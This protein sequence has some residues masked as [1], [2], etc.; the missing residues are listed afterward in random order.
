V[1]AHE[2]RT[3]N[4]KPYL[5]PVLKGPRFEAHAIPLEM[6]RDFAVLEEMVVEVAKWHFLREHPER[7]RAPRGFSDGVSLTLSGV[8]D[9]S[10]AAVITLL[11][12]PSLLFHSSQ[13]YLEQ[14]RDS[15]VGAISAAGANKPVFDYL[16]PKALAYFDRL[17]RSLRDGE[18]IEFPSADPSFP[19]RLTKE[20]RRKLL[21]ASPE[22]TQLTEEIEV[23]GA[24]HEFNQDAM[25]FQMTL[26]D[27]GAIPGSIASQ[28]FE[29]VMEAFA[30][31]KQG[32][33]ILIRGIGRFNRLERLQGIDSIEHATVL[34]AQDVTT[35]LQELRAIEDGW[36]DGS[37][38]APSEEGLNWLEGAVEQFYP[39]SLPLP[40]IYPV[41]TGAVQLEWPIASN[42]VSLEIDLTRRSGEW[43]VLD[44]ATETE[45]FEELDLKDD[46]SWTRVVQRLKELAGATNRDR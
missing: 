16:P 24:I 38:L 40:Y 46:R 19:A 10:A 4:V 45:E 8:E 26:P 32:V 22:V 12:A 41:P 30:G 35:R 31:Y 39:D 14:A 6:L 1:I 27:G 18:S 15:I 11:F 7:K 25:T 36:F 20:V 23:R 44:T 43:H 29:T 5:R 21:L 3:M 17:G 33:K 13:G 28:H 37:G 34:D 42:A 2:S 9:G